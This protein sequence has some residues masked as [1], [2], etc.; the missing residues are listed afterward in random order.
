M[1]VD[2]IIGMGDGAT[3]EQVIEARRDVY[4]MWSVVFALLTARAF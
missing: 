4:E 1:K 2:R 3:L